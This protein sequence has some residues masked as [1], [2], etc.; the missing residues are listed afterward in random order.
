MSIYRNSNIS[1]ASRKIQR[2]SNEAEANTEAPNATPE[3]EVDL[4]SLANKLYSLLRQEL[5]LERE[6]LGNKRS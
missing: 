6:R 4:Q 2:S 3:Q 1:P 5:Q